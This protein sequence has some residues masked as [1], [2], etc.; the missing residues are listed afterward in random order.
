MIIQKYC[1]TKWAP[2]NKRHYTALGYKFTSMQVEFRT[3]VAHLPKSSNTLIACACDEC[4]AIYNIPWQGISQGKNTTKY[5]PTHR[6]KYN[7]K[8]IS[9]GMFKS[10]EKRLNKGTKRWKKQE[11]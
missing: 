11:N 5:C 8:S 6:Q 4:G 9:V 3:Q 7:N 10:W 1:I 2:R